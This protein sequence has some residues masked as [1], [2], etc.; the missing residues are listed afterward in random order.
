[1]TLWIAGAAVLV[2]VGGSTAMLVQDRM[3]PPAPSTQPPPAA[4]SAGGPVA[5][6]RYLWRPVAIGGGG[7]ISGL[8]TDPRGETLLARADVYG[9]YRWDKALD[10]W[11]PLVTSATMPASMAAQ[12]S[13]MGVYEVAVAPGKPERIFL[14]M[15]GR[16]F[17]SDDGGQ[18]FVEP[19]PQAPFPFKWDANGEFRFAGPFI[20]VSPQDADIVYLGT[21]ADGLWRSADGGANWT[22]V[23][24]VPAASNVEAA[25]GA[26]P[27]GIPVWFDPHQPG[28]V[29]AASP[30]HGLFASDA[31]GAAFARVGGE[32]GPGTIWRGAFDAR[33]GFYAIDRVAKQLWALR[34]GGWALLSAKGGLDAAR[35]AGVDVERGTDRVIATDEGGGAWCSTDAGAS[36]TALGKSREP[37]AGDPPWLR[38]AEGN[39]YF[40][41]GQVQFDPRREGRLWV[42]AGTGPYVAD[43]KKGCGGSLAWKSQARGIE[44]L[45]AQ[46]VVQT[47]GH[48][49]VFAALDFGIHVKSDLNRFSETFG[50][51]PRALIAAQKIDWSPSDPNFLVTN[52]S[53]TRNCCAEDGDAVLA[54]YSLDGGASWRKFDSLPQPPGTQAD[55]PWRMAYG[56]IAVAADRTDNIVWLPAEDKAPYYT[57]DRGRSWQRVVFPGEKLPLTGAYGFKWLPRRTLAA[58]RVKPGT[59]YLY[60]SGSKTNPDLTGLWSTS[61]GGRTWAMAHRGEIAPDSQYAAKLRSVPGQAGHLF[62]TSA[63][64]ESADAGLRRSTDGGATWT[65]V[66]R[67]SHVDDVAF[68]KAARR[69]GYPTIFL[70]GRVD[71][72]YG[73]W[74]SVDDAQSWQLLAAFPLGRIDRVNVVGA[75]MDVFGRVYLGFVGSGWVYGE[76]APCQ[77]DQKDVEQRCVALTE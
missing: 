37:G 7:Y 40:A 41:S 25:G 49:P 66:A 58:D 72:R 75:D 59:F 9:A 46:D 71:G 32:S 27:A 30:G 65:P 28:R 14:A 54:G 64:L 11:V 63:V 1:M 22:R 42:A 45:V 44:E 17:R 68:G 31:S 13:G 35:F 26:Q 56:V 53:D 2:A 51:K 8:A 10:R 55:D 5:D 21:P 43:L 12:G 48:A 61:D 6:E 23:T 4:S 77:P 18:H 67:V 19:S 36:W 3:G 69:G 29:L 33:G 62:F 20:A 52:A 15:A 73:V 76:P 39:S 47:P 57:L 70:S 38:Y 16:M 34:D 74:R 50:P 24:D 60:H